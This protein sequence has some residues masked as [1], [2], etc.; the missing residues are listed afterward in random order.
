MALLLSASSRSKARTWESK[1]FVL[2]YPLNFD[3]FSS[4]YFETF[5]SWQLTSAAQCLL[6]L[7]SYESNVLCH[8]MVTLTAPDPKIHQGPTCRDHNFWIMPTPART[9]SHN[10]TPTS[11]YTKVIQSH[12]MFHD[13]SSKTSQTDKVRMGLPLPVPTLSEGMTSK[14]TQ[15]SIAHSGVVVFF[16]LNTSTQGSGVRR[17]GFEDF[18]W[19][20]LEL[21]F[22]GWLLCKCISSW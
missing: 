8:D 3:P 12:T 4:C 18:S 19:H 11:S 17:L 16:I 5:A 1:K 21:R 20:Q 2:L 10:H 13:S 6:Q 9:T 15:A 14:S 22:F 7:Q